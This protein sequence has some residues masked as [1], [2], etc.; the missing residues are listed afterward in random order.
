VR[1]AVIS[2][3]LAVHLAAGQSP[4]LVPPLPPSVPPFDEWLAELRAEAATRGIS[5][6]LI[7]RTL[8]GLQPIPQ[9][10]ERDRTQAEFALDLGDYL[11]RRITPGMLRTARRMQTRHRTLI[12]RVSTKYGVPSRVIVA[13]WGLESN[14]GGFVGVRPTVPTLVTLAYDPRRGPMFRNELLTA[15]ELVDRGDVPLDQLKGSW[16]GALGQPQF[17]PSSYVLYAQDFDG[18]GRRDIWNSRGDVFASMAFFLQ[19]HGW[20]RGEAWGREVKAAPPLRAK[21]EELP[22]RT[23]GCR[24]QRVMTEPRP[25]AEWRRLGLRTTANRPLP[26]VNR[27]ASLVLAGTRTFLVYRNYEALLSY[28]CAHSY[29]LSVGLLSDRLQ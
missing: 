25:L 17:M 28:N 14:F 3:A 26:P 23:E 8:T 11:K 12:T 29:A 21:L 4:P 22:R 15:L 9:V 19:Q 10:L 2:I 20:M 6:E 1:A 16:A 5:A 7:E 13:L 27:T 24:A 18:D